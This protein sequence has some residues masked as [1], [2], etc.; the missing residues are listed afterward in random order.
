MQG[1]FFANEM[2]I[3]FSVKAGM[4]NRQEDGISGSPERSAVRTK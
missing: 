2:V 4:M 3:I 1:C